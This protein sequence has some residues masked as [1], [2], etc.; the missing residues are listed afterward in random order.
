VNEELVLEG[1]LDAVEVAEV[2]RRAARSARPTVSAVWQV[3][4]RDGHGRGQVLS[5]M[6]RS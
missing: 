5:S 2:D 6:M 4:L 1:A 3:T